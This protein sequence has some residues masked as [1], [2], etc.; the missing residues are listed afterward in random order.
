MPLDIRIIA[1][2]HR[3]LAEMSANGEFREDLFYRLNVFPVNIPPFRERRIDL[4]E[5]VDFF[6]GNKSKDLKLKEVPRLA[7]GTMDR[8]MAYDWPGN[9]RELE[10]MVE[11]ALILYRSGELEFD[12]I[13]PTTPDATL[14]QETTDQEEITL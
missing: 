9:V 14:K 7:T 1:A 6:I 4:P 2:T 8:L 13:F 10:N 12:D 5:F 3:N 11:R